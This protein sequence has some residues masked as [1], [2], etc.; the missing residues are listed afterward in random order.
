MA[1]SRENIRSEAISILQKLRGQEMSRDF[2][3]DAKSGHNPVILACIAYYK[4][5][6]PL[7]KS[8]DDQLTKEDCIWFYDN[9]KYDGRAEG[10]IATTTLTPSQIREVKFTVFR[11]WNFVQI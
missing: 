4:Q 2:N 5:T 1:E 7:K 11:Y 10:H 9:F 3:I 6:R 8:F